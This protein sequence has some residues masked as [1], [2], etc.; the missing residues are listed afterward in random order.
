MPG[1]QVP[2]GQ[3][4]AAPRGQGEAVPQGLQNPQGLQAPGGRRA[5][6][7]VGSLSTSSFNTEEVRTWIFW[8]YFKRA[9]CCSFCLALASELESSLPEALCLIQE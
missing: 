1:F 3:E 9:S 7:A 5:S 4:R 8:E 2:R 6:P